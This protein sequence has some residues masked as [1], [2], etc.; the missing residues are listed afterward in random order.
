M[1]DFSLNLETIS[2]LA[3]RAD[4]APT[5][6]ESADYISGTALAGSLATL[7]RLY[8]QQN[9]TQF[10]ELFLSGQVNFPDL[11]PA[12]FGSKKMQEALT[13]PVYALPK[14]AQ[15][16]KRFSGFMPLPDE[17]KVTK[18]ERHGAR[19]ALLDWAAFELGN[20]AQKAGQPIDVTTLL[21]SLR[22]HKICPYPGCGKPMDHFAGYYRRSEDGRLATSEAEKRLQTRTG[23]NRDTGTVQEGILYNRT[24]FQEHTRFWGRLKVSED[25]ITPLKTFIEEVG[26]SGLL[27]VGTG[28]TRGMGKVHVNIKPIAAEQHSIETFKKNLETFNNTLKEVALKWFPQSSYDLALKPFYFAVTLHSPVII[29]DP[30][31]RYMGTLASRTLLPDTP[32]DTITPVYQA[33]STKRVTGWNE[34]WGT[35]RT[36]EY[37]IDTGSVFL[38][39]SAVALDDGMCQALFKLEEEG[40][41][42]RRAEGFG[43]LR[44]SDPFHLE[45]KLR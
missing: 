35:P 37:A 8:Y 5:R 41:G 11:Y 12:T 44:I 6:A 7:Y 28:R 2:P 26:L 27:R 33:A 19:D 39:A 17:K 9:D 10:E 24:V 29:R 31:L 14:T 34:L 18:D 22:E 30:L 16:C 21:K 20:I 38:F 42:E 23:I 40:I 45:E 32:E 36:N 3:I 43:R 4:H 15:S 25:L 1:R 13:A